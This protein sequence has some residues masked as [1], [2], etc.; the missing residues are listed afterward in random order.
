MNKDFRQNTEKRLEECFEGCLYFSVGRLF[1]S[2]DRIATEL[3][4]EIELSPTHAYLMLA[5]NECPK[6]SSSPSELADAINLDPSTV[7]RLI[8]HLEKLKFVRRQKDGRMTKIELLEKGSKLM[9]RIRDTW[10][11]FYRRYY[12][13]FGETNSRELVQ[14]MAKIWNKQRN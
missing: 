2:I 3:F 6:G 14:T 12:E 4:K 7:T 11:E 10:K 5:L 1:R 13:E 8:E 9:P